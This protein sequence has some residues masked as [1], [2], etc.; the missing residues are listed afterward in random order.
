MQQRG[1]E[2]D[3]YTLTALLTASERVGNWRQALDVFDDF[4]ARHIPVISCNYNS[5]IYTLATGGE[6]QKVRASKLSPISR[7]F[8]DNICDPH[9]SYSKE[10]DWNLLDDADLIIR[11]ISGVDSP[12]SCASSTDQDKGSQVN[13]YRTHVVPHR[14][15]MFCSG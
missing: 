8:H 15:S 9:F 11:S 2:P 14:H 4:S 10:M 6:W 12:I 7:F 1:L 13:T 3:S 5:L